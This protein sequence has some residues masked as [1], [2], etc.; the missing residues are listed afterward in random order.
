[1]IVCQSI[2]PGQVRT[3]RPGRLIWHRTH[4]PST[5]PQL[6]AVT[7]NVNQEK[8]DKAPDAWKPPKVSYW[9]AYAT[10]WV[11]VKRYYQ[12]TITSA[13]KTTLSQMLGRC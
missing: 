8:S 3:T 12:L 4:A 13:E 10:D 7:D 9:C 1:M 2:R 5:R 11:A 6:L